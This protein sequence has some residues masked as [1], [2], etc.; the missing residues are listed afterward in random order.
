[1]QES[2]ERV[3]EKLS[4]GGTEALQTM[5]SEFQNQLTGAST[6]SMNTVVTQLETL[7]TTLGTTAASMK[8]GNDELRGALTE[9][10]QSMKTSS[11]T[12]KA[13]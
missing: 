3:T 2:F 11:E 1:M 9:V 7:S 13:E 12:F 10:L 4:S 8:T 6:D 5:V